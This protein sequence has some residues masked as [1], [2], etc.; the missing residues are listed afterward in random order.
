VKSKRRDEQ[1]SEL[2]EMVAAT[3]MAAA[4]G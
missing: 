4:M 1:M 2:G 3:V